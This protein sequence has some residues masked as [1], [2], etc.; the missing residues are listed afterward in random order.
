MALTDAV[1]YE[2]AVELGCDLLVTDDKGIRENVPAT[3]RC[4][5]IGMADFMARLDP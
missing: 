3:N 1:I 5:P 4:Q 2:R